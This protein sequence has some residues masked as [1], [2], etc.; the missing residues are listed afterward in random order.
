MLKT[1]TVVPH[2]H[3]PSS[4]WTPT[5]HEQEF[6]RQEHDI[7]V[8]VSAMVQTV[9]GDFDDIGAARAQLA[10]V[11]R[12]LDRFEATLADVESALHRSRGT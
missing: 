7:L 12:K 10:A 6:G 8:L 1:V 5:G 3:I 11:R 4:Y 2:V 9:R